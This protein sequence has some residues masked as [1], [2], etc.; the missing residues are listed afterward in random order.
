MDKSQARKMVWEKLRH[1]AL[2]DSRFHFEFQSYI[3]DFIGSDQA[4]VRLIG[5]KIY[6]DSRLLFITPDN[7]LE[8]LRCRAL[9]DGKTLLVTS[10]AIRRGFYVLEPERVSPADYRYASTLDGMERVGRP[11]TLY[12]LKSLGKIDLVVTGA[13]VI[14]LQ[15]VRFG[16]GHGFFDL[17]WGMLYMVGMVSPETILVAFVHD[18]QI[19]DLNLEATLYD[20]VCDMIVTPSQ[21]IAM[22]NPQ[23]PTTGILWE[24]LEPGMLESIPPLQ[25]L[26]QGKTYHP[27]E[28]Q[29]HEPTRN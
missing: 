2:P 4:L 14:N 21:I 17:E 23:K 13:S 5:L 3:P 10:Y 8:G 24:K 1:V 29:D 27:H 28:L 6:Q 7:C 22:E 9:Q 16:K 12:E 25:E 26:K 20:S 19:V 15:G 11:V 18:Y